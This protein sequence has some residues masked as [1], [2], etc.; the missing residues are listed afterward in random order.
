MSFLAS[1]V[2]LSWLAILLLAFAM[3]GLLR[4]VRILTEERTPASTVVSPL[5]GTTVDSLP[6]GVTLGRSG[7]ISLTLFASSECSV[8]KSR[9]REL[10]DAAKTLPRDVHVEAV[11]ADDGFE[12]SE[13]LLVR[14]QQRELFSHLRIPVTPYVVVLSPAG[15]IAHAVAVGSDSSFREVVER[16]EEMRDATAA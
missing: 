15:R 6:A 5:V 8:C 3:A 1:A 11:F 4:Q 12:L 16:V 14:R 10:Q 13:P 7:S 9:L 2:L